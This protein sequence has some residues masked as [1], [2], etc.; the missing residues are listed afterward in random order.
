[1]L[2]E[3]GRLHWLS[4]YSG[5]SQKMPVSP[6]PQ[7]EIDRY[8]AEFRIQAR[9]EAPPL[10][11]LEAA[12]TLHDDGVVLYRGRQYR[13]RATPYRTGLWLQAMMY[14]FGQLSLHE[15]TPDVL[16][17][18]L[19]A[20][21]AAIGLMWGLVRWPWSWRHGGVNPFRDAEIG[22]V[23]ALADFSRLPG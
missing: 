21:E 17:Q 2:G 12:T 20:L 5:E 9:L 18:S 1:V 13:T 6:L 23:R 7:E 16:R 4:C 14:E 8:Q 3:R 22:E 19:R 15:P 10:G 11:N